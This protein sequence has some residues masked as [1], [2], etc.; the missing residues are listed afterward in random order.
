MSQFWIKFCVRQLAFLQKKNSSLT[1]NYLLF[2]SGEGDNIRVYVRVRPPDKH[3]ET[4]VD[5]TPCLEVTSGNTI[6]LQSKPDP[7]NFS[8]DHVADINTTQVS[9]T[10]LQKLANKFCIFFF[11]PRL[12]VVLTSSS[13][14]FNWSNYCFAIFFPAKGTVV[15]IT[16][17]GTNVKSRFSLKM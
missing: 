6:V 9:H 3:L 13:R 10:L 5:R 15:Y 14:L 12:W 7:K 17:L 11:C 16:I 1:S 4:D 8:F 2:Y